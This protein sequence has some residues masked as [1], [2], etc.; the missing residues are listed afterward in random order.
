MFLG[1]SSR[2]K[3][4]ATTQVF[5]CQ[6]VFIKCFVIYHHAE[7]IWYN[8]NGF[9]SVYSGF[10]LSREIVRM[11]KDGLTETNNELW[12]LMAK[13][14]HEIVLV[15]QRE[16]KQYHIPLRQLHALRSIQALDHNATI[17]ELSK[18]MERNVNVISRQVVRME[19]DGLIKRIQNTP[20]SNLLR[21]ELTKK[22]TDILTLSTKSKENTI[23]AVLSSLT[24][25]RRRQMESI[26]KEILDKLNEYDP[27]KISAGIEDSTR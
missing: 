24:E 27:E 3:Q 26:L 10:L 25:I 21:L 12:L 16:L 1:I 23:D 22:G 20:K 7:F 2:I 4:N 11:G 6:L 15:R 5:V 19:K 14:N 18:I 9:Y 13:V 8:L 17:A